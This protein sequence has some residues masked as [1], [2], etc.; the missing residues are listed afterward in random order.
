MLCKQV[1]VSLPHWLQRYVD[2]L[3]EIY[4]EKLEDRMSFV[5][6]ITRRNIEEGTG[7]PFGAAIFEKESGKL[8]SVGVNVV[9]AQSNCTAHAEMV[10]FMM[11][12]K[13]I[14][15]YSLKGK[16]QPAHQL[17]ASAQPCAMCMGA[18]V[19]SGVR[20][21]VFGSLRCDIQNINNFDE[22]PIPEKWKDEL[23]KRGINVVEGV[24]RDKAIEIHKLYQRT[25]GMVY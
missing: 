21:L 13:Q 16:N 25:S 17:I 19:W 20:E 6:D 9:V 11:A 8:V 24:L 7:G 12:G 10:A 5:L 15:S 18:T 14:G 23:A 2:E 22:G 3:D 4:I 1:T